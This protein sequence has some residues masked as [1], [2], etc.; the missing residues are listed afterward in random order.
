MWRLKFI[1]KKRAYNTSH[2][3]VT[4]HCK[5]NQSYRVTF[6][7]NTGSRLFLL[8]VFM[9]GGLQ[10]SFPRLPVLSFNRCSLLTPSLPM[11]YALSLP[12]TLPR[13]VARKSSPSNR[14]KLDVLSEHAHVSRDATVE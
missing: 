3:E 10:F 12:A 2:R 11:T 6:A 9:T 5:V 14:P 13:R 4:S 8:I 1:D 7:Q